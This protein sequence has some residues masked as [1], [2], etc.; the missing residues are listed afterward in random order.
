MA[1]R[2]DKRAQRVDADTAMVDSGA[3]G[4]YYSPDAP[5]DG[6]DTDAPPIVVGT[7][8]GQRQLSS[9]AANHQI[10]N[11]PDEFPR[12]GHVMPPFTHTLIGVGPMC[13]VGCTVTF[14]KDAVVVRDEKDKAI[15]VGWR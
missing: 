9:A 2:A 1:R 11:L 10:P 6:I 4:F 3:N 5:V 15:I 14:T 12:G 8:S 13:N 7:A